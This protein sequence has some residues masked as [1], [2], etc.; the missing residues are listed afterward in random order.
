MNL[1]LH[2]LGGMELIGMPI[3][4]HDIEPGLFGAEDVSCEVVSDH[5]RSL[6]W[7]LGLGKRIVEEGGRGFVGTG[8]F[9]E[10]DC[11]EVVNQ[12]RSTELAVL[13]LVEAVAAHVESVAT[14]FEVLHQLM[15]TLDHAG[16]TG[17]EIEEAI[18]HLETIL[19][20]GRGHTYG[21][22]TT[23]AFDHQVVACNL[24]VGIEI[25]ELDIGLPIGNGEVFETFEISIKMML[26]KEF[27]KGQDSVA[28][29]VIEGIVEVDEEVGVHWEK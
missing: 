9:T 12:L 6:T 11:V 26:L 15:R 2:G 24:S 28:V 14:L 16:L 7:S 27:G 22:G 19:A 20:A 23:E 5:Q 4:E 29:G 3:E 25:P 21:Q 17:T 18:A 13:H 1:I 10:Y 8:I